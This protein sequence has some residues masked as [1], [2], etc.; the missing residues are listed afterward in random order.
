M[1]R[2]FVG[3]DELSGLTGALYMYPIAISNGV[4]AF[5]PSFSTTTS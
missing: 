2:C 5:E 1:P 4:E 3:L